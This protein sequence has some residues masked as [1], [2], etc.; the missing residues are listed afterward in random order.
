MITNNLHNIN[1]E[2][3]VLS[4][5]IFDPVQYEEIAA[6]LKPEDFYHPFHQHL[7]MAMEELFRNDQ[8]IDEEFL[9][10]KLSHEFDEVAFLDVLSANPLS[11]AH[12]YI[13][14]IKAKAKNRKMLSIVVKTKQAIEEGRANATEVAAQIMANVDSMFVVMI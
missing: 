4:T 11:N 3:A 2:R 6:Q 14:E 9:K 5:I 12:A 13:K 10:E 8:P 7:F 1:I